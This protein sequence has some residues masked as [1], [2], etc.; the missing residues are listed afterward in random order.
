VRSKKGRDEEERRREVGRMDREFCSQH[1]SENLSHACRVVYDHFLK[2]AGVSNW[3]LTILG[4]QAPTISV[5]ATDPDGDVV[6]EI[7]TLTMDTQT[8]IH[9]LLLRSYEEWK[10]RGRPQFKDVPCGL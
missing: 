10:S 6:A 3:G 7:I 1:I 9:D 4:Q 2:E 8:E 5:S